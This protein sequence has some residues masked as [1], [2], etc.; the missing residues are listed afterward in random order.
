MIVYDAVLVA[1]LASAAV[2]DPAGGDVAPE[3]RAYAVIGGQSTVTIHVGKGGVFGFAGH[4]H[5]VAASAVEGRI[6]ADRAQIAASSVS[7]SFAAAALRVTGKGE[8]AD[9]VPAVQEAMLGPNVLDAQRFPAVVFRSTSV[10][11]RPAGTDAYELQVAGELEL[12]GVTQPLSV[13]LRV[14]LSQDGLRASGTVTLRQTA[15]GIKPVSVGGVVKV[16][17]ELKITFDIVAH[18]EIR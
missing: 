16:K 7:L 5:E 11:G 9:D 6:V 8:P 18:A 14:E 17:D 12:H 13:P 4:E 2:V 3:V 10:A 1:L 15:F